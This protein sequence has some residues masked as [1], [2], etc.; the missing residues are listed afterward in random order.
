MKLIKVDNF[1]RETV[2]DV[3]VEEN[4]SLE[5]AN[6]KA[7]ALN[8]KSGLEGDWFYRVVP[9]DH[10]LYLFDFESHY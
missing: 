5:I 8:M 10:K 2:S 9:D 4:L 3:L 7:L 1:L 6:S